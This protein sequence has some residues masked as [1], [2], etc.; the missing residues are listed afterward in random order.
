MEVGA[1]VERDL[2]P[3]SGGSEVLQILVTTVLKF[4]VAGGLRW[5]EGGTKVRTSTLKLKARSPNFL[6]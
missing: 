3:G 1:G 5:P 6:S 4:S 2:R